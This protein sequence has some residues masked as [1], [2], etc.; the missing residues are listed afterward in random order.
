MEEEVDRTAGSVGGAEKARKGEQK[1]EHEGMEEETGKDEK[2]RRKQ[3]GMSFSPLAS[4]LR[5][6]D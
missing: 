2:G 4:Q 3:L 1:W 5:C 6:P